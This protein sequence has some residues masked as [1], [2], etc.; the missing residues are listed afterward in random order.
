MEVRDVSRPA[1]VTSISVISCQC[2]I[3][4]TVRKELQ[5]A[6]NVV[7]G[8]KGTKVNVVESVV[9]AILSKRVRPISLKPMRVKKGAFVYPF[10]PFP[11]IFKQC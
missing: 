6:A 3:R 7:R 5:C 9:P 4:V 1:T 8:G 10:A 2:Y 11:S